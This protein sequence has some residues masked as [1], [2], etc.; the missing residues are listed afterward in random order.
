MT[1]KSKGMNITAKEFGRRFRKALSVPFLLDKVCTTNIHEFV[2]TYSTALGSSEK[3]FLFPLLT[4]AAA[5]MGTD[6]YIE[7]S[8]SWQEPPILWTLVITPKSLLRIDVA[9]HLKQELLST[10]NDMW[11]LGE[12][13]ESGELKRKFIFD[14]FNLEQLQNMLRLSNGHGF[15]IYN[16]IR[17]LHQCMMSPEEADIMHRLHFGLGLFADSRV[18]KSTVSKTRMNFSVISTPCIVQQTLNSAP[19]FQELFYECFLTVCAEEK[20]VKF[21]QLATAPETDK[22][23]L[24]FTSLIKIHSS[25]AVVYKLSPEA[26]EK[27]GQIHDELTDKARQMARKNVEHSIF[28][29][30]VSYL[31]RLSCL[32]HVLDNALENINDKVPVSNISSW[33][34]EISTA[35]VLFARE[36]LGHIVEQRHSLLEP[37]T[38]DTRNA[39]PTT[40][41]NLGA[42]A[43]PNFRGQRTPQGR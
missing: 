41:I 43:S 25:R 12:E 22:L 39:Q 32:L 20:L 10:Q 9:E 21:S 29:P 4:C 13:G 2:S 34:S 23:R 6:C 35:N 8:D 40:P 26:A 7:L 28:Q 30:A 15:G 31:A 1:E 37:T 17:S 33:N 3:A 27:F 38:F 36:L 24:I 11:I 42:Q 5:C 19:N 18:A 14:M 16:S